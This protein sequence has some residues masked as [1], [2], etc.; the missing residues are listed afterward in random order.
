[1]DK[2]NSE[3][4]LHWVRGGVPV[5]LVLFLVFILSISFLPSDLK[6][7][8]A[9]E[10]GSIYLNGETGDD[11]N[12]GMSEE[13]AVKTFE[14]AKELAEADLDIKK[15]YI[16]GTVD[17]S[18]E[19]SLG[20][21]NAILMRNPG[22]RD[23]LLRVKKGETA[24]LKDITVDG[25]G[26]NDR[27]TLKS[28]L[29]VD[30]DLNI[31]DGTVLENNIVLDL[32]NWHVYGGAIYTDRYKD[33]KR[34]INM[35]GGII[36][37]N[38]AHLGGGIYLGR[39]TVLNMSGGV[40]ENN[41][42]YIDRSK[43]YDITN[44]EAGGGICTYQSSTINL[45]GDAVIS[46]N[47]A[48]ECGGGISL[49]SYEPYGGLRCILNMTG[50]VIKG[51]KAGSAGGGIFVQTDNRD[52][53]GSNIANISA[54]EILNNEMTGLG[55]TDKMFGGGGIYVNGLSQSLQGVLNLKNAL[56]TDNEAKK[57]G[58]GY[59]A[60]PVST[61]NIFE[62]DGIAI[63][64]NRAKLGQDIDIESGIFG[65]GL[66]GGFP[67]YTISPVMLG[68]TPYRWKDNDNNEVPLTRLTGVLDALRHQTMQ[69]HTDVTEDSQAESLAKVIIKGNKSTTNGGGIGSNGGLV[70][71]Q[72]EVTNI[73]VTKL[74]KYDEAENRPESI[75]VELYRKVEEDPDNPIFIGT[76]LMREENGSWELNFENLPK[77]DENGKLYR[78]TIKEQSIEGYAVQLS[79]NQNSGYTLTNIPETT[80]QVEKK[81]NGDPTNQV[82]ISLLSDG[83]VKGKAIITAA[84]DWKHIFTNLPKFDAEDGHVIRY[85][86]K[87]TPIYGYTSLISGD[88]T[89]GYLV[90]NTK[91]T[92]PPGPNPPSPDP[93]TPP[94]PVTPGRPV[95]PVPSTPSTPSTPTS[96]NPNTPTVAGVSR[97][98][99]VDVVENDHVPTVLGESRPP[100]RADKRGTLTEDSSRLPLW[101]SLFTFSVL[102]FVFYT[103]VKKERQ[104]KL[105]NNRRRLRGC[106]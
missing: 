16:N 91:D 43:T 21:T 80:V 41:K 47:S 78:Y 14:K 102:A 1:M 96:P 39:N 2:N 64:G 75:T 44:C 22:F 3:P 67:P 56:I 42:A 7:V 76:G 30:G 13:N 86:V 26:E 40:I 82:E 95:N 61:T 90:T 63:Y 65:Y 48:T 8:Y 24:T 10:A 33:H 68:G 50:G 88:V 85:E 94:S 15:I 71:G 23:H 79:G 36:R 92:T 9:R 84:D 62:K 73:K 72:K 106:R 51:N 29:L 32:D 70:A 18:G 57:A 31:T 93:Y 59:A 54:G 6:Q 28:L 25:G 53:N 105:Y 45:S 83:T 104:C 77:R 27:L 60:C 66:H 99:P 98:N 97:P 81:W 49:G 5:I 87:E 52:N 38:S 19:I 37:N 55:V 100:V 101:A 103:I 46:G 74:W 69:L 35:T 58:G 89:S 17:I 11:E 34:T 12:D 4:F 20:E